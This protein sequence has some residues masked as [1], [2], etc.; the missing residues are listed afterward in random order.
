MQTADSNQ[1]T[2]IFDIVNSEG[3]TSL[4]RRVSRG[5]ELAR[6]RGLTLYVR[7][8]GSRLFNPY[9]RRPGKA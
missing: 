9:I 2:E 1:T 4:W 5:E 8:G 7:R 3:I 6:D